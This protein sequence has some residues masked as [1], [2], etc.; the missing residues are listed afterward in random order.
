MVE[1]IWKIGSDEGLHFEFRFDTEQAASRRNQAW[2]GARLFFA[3]DLIWATETEDDEEAPLYWSWFDLLEYLSNYWP[4]LVL[5]QNYPIPVNPS[6]PGKLYE[7]AERRWESF[8]DSVV[9]EEDM[10]VYA[11]TMR[12]DLALALN[13]AF[14]P[15]V[16]I[17]RRGN[18]C[19]LSIESP[20]MDIVRP[21]KEVID[22]LE[23]LGDMLA[24]VVGEE[25]S[26]YAGEIVRKWRQKD[27]RI[28]GLK[29]D[30]LSGMDS[31]AR[32][33]LEG[34][35]DPEEYWEV[36]SDGMYGDSEFAAAAR[37]TSA[38]FSSTI[39]KTL[40]EKIRSV[41][42]HETGVLDLLAA[43][44]SSVIN[45][46]IR[47]YEQGYFFAEWLRN[48]LK[49]GEETLVEPEQILYDWNVEIQ[50]VLLPE[51]ADKLDALAAWG[52]RHGPVVIMNSSEGARCSHAYG[53]RT[54]LAHEICHL[55]LDREHG[56]PMAEVLGGRTPESLEQRAR[57]FAAEFLLP[58]RLAIKK[59]QE[60][61]SVESVVNAL[62]EQYQ[63]STE[64]AARQIDNS[65]GKYL[66]PKFLQA[67]LA[68]MVS[69]L[70]IK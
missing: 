37:M 2:G 63:V 64:V 30:I 70:N 49:I 18:D 20:K 31:E 56:L 47:P 33:R 6:F 38:V 29:L 50:I 5:E 1:K 43:K 45:P 4:W 22:T 13:G 60:N 67:E 62:S 14:V 42:H 54:T 53:R 36:S 41:K 7:A 21:H 59:M 11:F 28:D 24:D 48:E 46:D 9:E 52:P 27:R 8:S 32:K 19:Q 34:G 3:D 23:A 61:D 66:L 26:E 10:L 68:S 15:S 25:S 57:A 40:I 69:K 65:E 16:M 39:Q 44:A 35:V 12:H 58:R 55:L 17:L 51:S